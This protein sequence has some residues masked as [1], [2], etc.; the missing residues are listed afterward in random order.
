M[1]K[2]S[3]HYTVLGFELMTFGTWVSSHNHSPAQIGTL[4]R[5][6]FSWNCPVLKYFRI[7]FC[8]TFRGWYS[9]HFRCRR[10]RSKISQNF[11][12]HC[13]SFMHSNP[14]PKTFDYSESI[15]SIHTHTTLLHLAKQFCPC[16]HFHLKIRTFKSHAAWYL[17]QL[18]KQHDIFLQT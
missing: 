9:P 12:V 2:M 4:L 14:T 6:C 16:S 3:I 1:W 8:F 11:F 10:R 17:C 15:I 18:N 5:F 13:L 7:V